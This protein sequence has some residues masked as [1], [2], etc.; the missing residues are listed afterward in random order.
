MKFNIISKLRNRNIQWEII[1]DAFDVRPDTLKA[2]FS[3]KNK[4]KQL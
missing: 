3:H 2:W 4:A 1:G